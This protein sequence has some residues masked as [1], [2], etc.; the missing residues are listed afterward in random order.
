[1]LALRLAGA[2]GWFWHFR[3]HWPEGRRWLTRVIAAWS[4]EDAPET[5]E[6]LAG[7]A[8]AHA[9]V[10]ASGLAW[11]ERDYA[12]ARVHVE[13]AVA[14][15]RASGDSGTLGHALG[16]G[17]LVALYYRDA[18][19]EPAFAESL[20]AFQRAEDEAGVA[21]ARLRLGIAAWGRGS[22]DLA[23]ERLGEALAQF[24]ALGATWGA[25]TALASLGDVARARADWGRVAQLCVEALQGYRRLRS[26]WY[27]AGSLAALGGALGML[28]ED[29]RAAHLHGA[30]AALFETIGM[31]LHDMDRA[32]YA[33]GFAAARGRLGE[34][35]YVAASNRGRSMSLDEL[36]A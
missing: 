13:A 5:P 19:P 22:L 18:D 9:R 31:E 17:G 21:L 24:R 10:A 30:S 2:L 20:A 14:L 15:A 11:A 27:V 7:S 32:E 35:T 4:Q 1:L 16:V 36:I 8:L 25:A 33:A 26:T 12:E 23:E 29:E 3:G 28:G 6:A 34:A